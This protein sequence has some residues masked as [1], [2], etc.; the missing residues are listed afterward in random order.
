MTVIRKKLNWVTMT[1]PEFLG[2]D[3]IIVF[4]SGTSVNNIP[5]GTLDTI[6]N[7]DKANLTITL[8]YGIAKFNSDFNFITD[9]EPLRWARTLSK[10]QQSRIVAHFSN[11]EK[12]CPY[13][14]RTQ[15]LNG[16]K[17]SFT[18]VNTLLCIRSNEALRDKPI[19]I[20][21]LDMYTKPEGVKYYDDVVV[22]VCDNNASRRTP[23]KFFDLCE[24]DLSEMIYDKS[25]IF[26]CNFASSCGLFEFRSPYE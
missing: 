26:N 3:R 19:Y 5:S 7:K 13:Y 17:S 11:A 20:Y 4:A 25:N 2:V 8:N 12:W 16:F 23:Q 10:W 21:G 14:F 1:R 24:R 15:E 18:L 9:K 6:F 22:G